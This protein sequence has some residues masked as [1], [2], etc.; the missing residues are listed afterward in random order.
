M[1]ENLQKFI[2]NYYSHELP[3]SPNHWETAMENSRRQQTIALTPV[4]SKV[5][6]IGCHTGITL[7]ALKKKN[8]QLFGIDMNPW[9]VNLARKKGIKVKKGD[10]TKKLGFPDNEFD[11]IILDHV[12][13]HVFDSIALLKEA[14]RV[15]KPG[16]KIIVGVPNMVSFRDRILVFFG[17]I[18]AYGNHT[19]HLHNYSAKKIQ[20]QLREAGFRQIKVQGTDIVIP[21]PKRPIV[22]PFVL[23]RLAGLSNCLQA[24]GEK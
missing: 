2:K 24:V 6:D 21:L 1:D 4:N 20:D 9:A 12:L 14:Y 17:H 19:D 16:G 7:E 13:E 8:C 5:L 18:P 23:K 3:D 10:I 22:F 15:L 11:A